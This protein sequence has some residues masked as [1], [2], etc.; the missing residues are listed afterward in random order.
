MA[1]ESPPCPLVSPAP[2]RVRPARTRRPQGK[3]ALGHIMLATFL[4]SNQ[5]MNLTT[6]ADAVLDADFST[7]STACVRMNAHPP[8]C[9]KHLEPDQDHGHPPFPG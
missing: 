3:A 8:D 4:A 2:Y 7:R 1:H 5:G 6:A 9:A